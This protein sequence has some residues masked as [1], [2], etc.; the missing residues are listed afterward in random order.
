MIFQMVDSGEHDAAKKALEELLF[1]N[2]TVQDEAEQRV[3]EFLAH[4]K[5]K[6][7]VDEKYKEMMDHALGVLDRMKTMEEHQEHQGKIDDVRRKI[8]HI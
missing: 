3:L 8:Q 5:A 6:K 1:S 4:I 2:W 7:A